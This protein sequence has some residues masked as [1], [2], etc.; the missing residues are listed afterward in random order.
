MKDRGIAGIMLSAMSS[1]S[2]KTVLCTALALA[3]KKR[4][5]NTQVLKCGPDYI[6]P[7]LHKRVLEETADDKAPLPGGCNIDPFLQGFRDTLSALLL[8]GIGE[9]SSQAGPGLVILEGVMGYYDGIGGGTKNSSWEIAGLTD[10]PVI[11]VIR[12][13]GAGIT[14]AALIK[15]MLTF[16]EDSKISGVILNDCK[17][18]LYDYLK[19][20]IERETGIPVLGFMPHFREAEIDSRHLGLAAVSKEDTRGLSER[21]EL[22]S[23]RLAETVDLDGI[24]KLSAGPGSGDIYTLTHASPD[25][26]EGQ[27]NEG[28]A[29]EDKSLRPKVVRGIR[30]AIAWDDAF[31]FYYRTSLRALEEA[32]A[33]LVFFSPIKDEKLPPGIFGLYLGGGYPELHLEGLSKNR[34]MIKSIS[35]AFYAGMPMIAECGGFMYLHKGV[36]GLK[37][38]G[39]HAA[40]RFELTGVIGGDAFYAGS[41]QRFGYVRLKGEDSMLFRNGEEIPAHEFHYYKSTAD[42]DTGLKCLKARKE[43]AGETSTGSEWIAGFY[44]DRLYAGFPHMDLS[45]RP[46]SGSH[47]AETLGERF[48]KRAEEFKS[49]GDR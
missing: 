5:I 27:A 48:V 47:T 13:S 41:L 40:D 32:G 3:F 42:C 6:D 7:L 15:G 49:C 36:S 4:G 22:L 29:F 18:S 45:F 2:G 28:P 9:R 43:R 11:L 1:G 30:I 39:A 20:V 38:P 19:P 25:L 34:S 10:T 23:D 46:V 17:K 44:S 26:P 16:R 24:L 37:A 21:F 12:P 8:Q 33:E 35:A 31:C 14:L